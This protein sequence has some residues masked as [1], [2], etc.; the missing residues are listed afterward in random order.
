MQVPIE[1]MMSQ[2]P[3]VQ[4]VYSKT[5]TAELAADPMPPNATDMFV[6]LKPRTDW[7]NPELPKEE[8]VSRLEGNLAQ[9]PGNA[10]TNTH[11]IQKRF[12]ELIADVRGELAATVLGAAS[13]HINRTP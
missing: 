12:N 11:P 1:R 9:I 3:E 5:G 4:F 8:L 2:Q 13:N 7:P 6:I 10:Y